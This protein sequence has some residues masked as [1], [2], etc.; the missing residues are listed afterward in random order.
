[1]SPTHNQRRCSRQQ[2]YHRH[3]CHHYLCHCCCHL[4]HRRFRRQRTPVH[5]RLRPLA[6]DTCTS[7][8]YVYASQTD[9]TLRCRGAVHIVRPPIGE[10]G[11]T[12]KASAARS[13]PVDLD[14]LSYLPPIHSWRSIYPS[15]SNVLPSSSKV[16][17]SSAARSTAAVDALPP[18]DPLGSIFP[19]NLRSQPAS[20]RMEAMA[21]MFEC[22]IDAHEQI[23]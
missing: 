21:T 16:P 22:D 1:M 6:P 19:S 5:P 17:F 8:T 18:I 2:Q 13:R 10:P 9:R 7:Y 3:R 15:F 23:L 11:E 14:Y 20:P 4:Y 12:P